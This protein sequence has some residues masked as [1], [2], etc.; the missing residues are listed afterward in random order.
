MHAQ[1][2]GLNH[3]YARTASWA[4]SCVLQAQL[5]GSIMCMHA[6]LPGLNHVYARTASWAQSC[7]YMHSFLGSIMCIHAQLPGLNHCIL[8]DISHTSCD[9]NISLTCLFFPSVLETLSDSGPQSSGD[10][11]GGG[12]G[13]K[14]E[15]KR[16]L[17]EAS[18]S[19]APKRRSTRVCL[20]LASYPAAVLGTSL[21]KFLHNYRFFFVR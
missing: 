4:Q 17:L 5:P 21:L 12:G 15:S 6:Q 9:G 8:L 10:E 18:E 20:Y 19:F 1:L 16:K 11:G 7:V 3:V 14:R 13:G 2:P